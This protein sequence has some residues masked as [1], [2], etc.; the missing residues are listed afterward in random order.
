VRCLSCQYELKGLTPSEDKG[1]RCPECGR[2]FDPSNPITFSHVS[3]MAA[4]VR[5]HLSRVFFVGL[6]VWVTV[7]ILF[8]AVGLH[9]VFGGY[10]SN[11]PLEGSLL[12]NHLNLRNDVWTWDG[13][14][15]TL[16]PLLNGPDPRERAAMTFDRHQQNTV[17]WAALGIKDRCAINGFCACRRCVPPTSTAMASWRSM[18]YWR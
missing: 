9:E 16:R 13:T 14:S 3:V 11:N 17:S 8:A 1:F 7:F 6:A 4:R 12:V 18:T 15:W 2:A 10:V 5:Y